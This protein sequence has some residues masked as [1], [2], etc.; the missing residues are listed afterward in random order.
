VWLNSLVAQLRNAF[1]SIDTVFS[2][3]EQVS[4]FGKA[5]NKLNPQGQE[6]R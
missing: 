2:Y 5:H 3:V 1:Q 6:K 4:P